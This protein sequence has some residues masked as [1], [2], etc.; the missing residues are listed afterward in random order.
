MAEFSSY[1]IWSILPNKLA[2]MRDFLVSRLQ[3]G[4]IRASTR[5]MPREAQWDRSQSLA[6]IPIR[7]TIFPRRNIVSLFFGGSNIEDLN[8]MLNEALASKVSGIILDIDSPGGVVQGVPEL[9]SAIYAG[10]QVKPVVAVATNCCASA[11]YWL[12]SA[13]SKIIV[14]PSAEIGSIGV[15]AEHVDYSKALEKAGIKPTL[16][17]AAQYKVEDNPYEPLGDE[18][19]AEI[20]RHVDRYY[21]MFVRSVARGR[22][23]SEQVARGA[24][25][26]KGRMKGASD[27]VMSGMADELG[28]LKGTLERMP[29]AIFK[30]TAKKELE[31]LSL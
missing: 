29:A 10:R 6:I 2:S 22:G 17:H 12:A 24:A 25:F 3:A 31:I 18:A 19:K 7:G 11:A 15:F 8:V 9:A 30:A 27:A 26:G 28:S 14:T 4:E 13:A 21:G 5:T 23:V 16:I 1:K 20:Q